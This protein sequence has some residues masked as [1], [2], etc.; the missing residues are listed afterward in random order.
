MMQ[1]RNPLMLGCLG[2][3]IAPFFSACAFRSGNTEQYIGPVLFRYAMPP[4]NNAYVSQIVRLGPSA[5]AGISWGV[6]MGM[7]ER[8]TVAPVIAATRQKE[9]TANSSHWL[10][11]LSFS[12]TPA[13]GEWNFSLL[14]LCVEREPGSFFLSRTITGVEIVFGEEANALTVGFA[15]RTLFTPPDNAISSLHFENARPL[16][17]QA[18][19]WLDVPEHGNLPDSLLKEITK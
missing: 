13:A 17:S 18:T 12:Q 10:M 6:A 5:E 3:L 16:E 19:V 4:N 14:Y 9:Q 1:S 2:L 7:S 15:H 11:P 8:I